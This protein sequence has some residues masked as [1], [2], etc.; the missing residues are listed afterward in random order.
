MTHSPSHHDSRRQTVIATLL[1]LCVVIVG[2]WEIMSN[3]NRG[4]SAD[5]E[6]TSDD[7]H[8]LIP[9]SDRWKIQSFPVRTTPMEPNITAFQLGDPEN[10]GRSSLVRLVHGYNMC[11]CMRI[12]GYTVDLKADTRRP[13]DYSA[14]PSTVTE[15]SNDGI[16]DHLQI[17]RVTSAGGDVSIWITTMLRSGD[18]AATDVDVRAMAF[19]RIGIPDDPNWMP[20]GVTLQSFRH[21]LRNI[22]MA[23]RAKWNNSRCDVLTFLGLRQPAWASENMLTLVTASKGAS[24]NPNNEKE[25]VNRAVEAHTFMLGELQR[26]R[27]TN[28][29]EE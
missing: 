8:G 5:F 3:R 6:L 10:S 15:Q 27:K 13:T 26:W 20:R 7:L 9:K 21:P 24:V 18:F 16:P 4:L 1:V 11:D 14:R 28:L 19:P 22:R 12:K 29:E 2:F 23:L 25:A 17:W